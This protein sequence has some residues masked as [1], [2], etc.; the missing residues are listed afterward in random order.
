MT[1]I[2]ACK[3]EP[4]AAGRERQGRNG[5]ASYSPVTFNPPRMPVR[6]FINFAYVIS[7]FQL[8][9]VEAKA[10]QLKACKA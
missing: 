4:A 3:G 5:G 7:N 6:F 1:S 8:D 2:K 10:P 9:A